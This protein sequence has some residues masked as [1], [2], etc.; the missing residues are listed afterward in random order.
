MAEFFLKAISIECVQCPI[1][2]KIFIFIVGEDEE[3]PVSLHD[4]GTGT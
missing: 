3:G 4:H 1:F 2:G